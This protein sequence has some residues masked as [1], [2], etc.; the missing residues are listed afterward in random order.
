MEEKR[1]SGQPAVSLSA[2][3][4]WKRKPEQA[5][6]LGSQ[7]FAAPRE[8]FVRS[9][10]Q[11]DA[12]RSRDELKLLEVERQILGSALTTIYEH[13]TK[14]LLSSKERDYLLGKYKSELKR[15]EEKITGKQRVVDLFELEETREK[16][17][18][19]FRQKLAEIEA[20]I[21][22]LSPDYATAESPIVAAF[23]EDP[24]PEPEETTPVRALDPPVTET[25]KEARVKEEKEEPRTKAEK[26]L[27]AIREE[28]LKAMERLEQIEAEG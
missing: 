7:E 6:S 15:L 10:K 13:Q 21:Q 18:Q 19:S 3:A 4:F 16:I 8:Q 5:E 17:A 20:R 25:T 22:K 26:R 14:G 28:V 27:E 9:V 1:P 2:L 24:T 11:I 12:E 23:A